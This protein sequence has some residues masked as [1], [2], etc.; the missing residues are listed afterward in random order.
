M[1]WLQSFEKVYLTKAASK[2]L[3]QF[4][5]SQLNTKIGSWFFITRF[6]VVVFI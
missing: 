3:P 4:T 1:Q 5:K 2:A 6:N